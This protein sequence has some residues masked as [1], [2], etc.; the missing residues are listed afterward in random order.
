MNEEYLYRITH[1]VMSDETS[2]PLIVKPEILWCLAQSLRV[3]SKH[4]A[5]NPW[6]KKADVALAKKLEKPIKARHPLP[7]IY[8]ME[9][10]EPIVRDQ[11]LLGIDVT[12]QEA[13]LIVCAVKLVNRHPDQRPYVRELTQTA[14]QS[15]GK[16]II[17]HH[18]DAWLLVGEG[19]S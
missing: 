12:M 6:G 17:E 14:A 18:P 10:L 8:K 15:I 19:W 16:R 13:H 4:P 3:A 11:E 1:E 2:V 7:D 5:K 9:D